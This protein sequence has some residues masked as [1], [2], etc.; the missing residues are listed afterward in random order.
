MTDVARIKRD[1][2]PKVAQAAGRWNLRPVP[3]FLDSSTR[4]TTCI[5]WENFRREQAK[6]KRLTATEAAR[7]LIDNGRCVSH[8]QTTARLSSKSIGRF[9]VLSAISAKEH[10]CEAPI[11][12][13][14][15]F[16]AD[17]EGRPIF[18]VSTK[19]EHTRDIARNGRISLFVLEGKELV[20]GTVAMFRLLIR[21]VQDARDQMATVT[22]I[23]LPVTSDA[24]SV[25]DIYLA[26]SPG[27]FW[28]DFGDFRWFRMETILNVRF[29]SGVQ[30][31]ARNVR[32]SFHTTFPCTFL[33]WP[34]R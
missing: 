2:L 15:N 24:S 18:S 4:P 33:C 14:V 25:R 23:A 3:L 16:V 34:F 9:G 12:S 7:T 19:A 30:T 17:T 13:Y 26:K 5:D 27:A 6:L 10:L 21:L 28:V 29:I 31:V 8:P 11:G 20:R 22:G 32:A 1:A